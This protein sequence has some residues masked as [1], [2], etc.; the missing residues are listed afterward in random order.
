MQH[1]HY[2]HQNSDSR[3]FLIL[4]ARD[5]MPFPRLVRIA[6]DESELFVAVGVIDFVDQLIEVV[7]LAAL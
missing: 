3:T 5:P 1:A 2:G 4:V 7:V 6:P